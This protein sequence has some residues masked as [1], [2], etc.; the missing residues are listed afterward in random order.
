MEFQS[1]F[2]GLHILEVTGL[3]EVVSLCTPAIIGI[4][5]TDSSGDKLVIHPA[6]SCVNILDFM[7]R[8]QMSQSVEHKHSG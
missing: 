8:A 4:I 3:G 6:M 1:V 2:K 7:Y 5:L